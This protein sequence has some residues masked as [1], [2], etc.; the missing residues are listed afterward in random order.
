[1]LLR[2]VPLAALL[3]TLIALLFNTF[4]YPLHKDSLNAPT[5]EVGWL[6]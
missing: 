2:F 6:F 4:A 1:M 3:V 5:H